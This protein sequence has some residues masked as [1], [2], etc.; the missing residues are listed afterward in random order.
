MYNSEDTDGDGDEDEVV[1]FVGMNWRA[2]LNSVR[3]LDDSV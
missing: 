2:E 3:G 1:Y